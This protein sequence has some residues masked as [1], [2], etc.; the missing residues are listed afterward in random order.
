MQNF[1]SIIELIGS[2]HEHVDYPTL[3]DDY[4]EK[5][6]ILK[7]PKSGYTISRVKPLRH[8]LI[9]QLSPE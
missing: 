8:E 9:I 3:R 5:L 2:E 1:I 4:A 6:S 7:I